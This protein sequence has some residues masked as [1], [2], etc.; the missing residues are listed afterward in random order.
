MQEREDADLRRNRTGAGAPRDD[1]AW[2][3]WAAT[4]SIV[5][6]LGCAVA[7]VWIVATREELSEAV[8][9]AGI[10]VVAAVLSGWAMWHASQA[11]IEGRPTPGWANALWLALLAA[12]FVG[13]VT[14]PVLGVAGFLGTVVGIFTV[15]V[16]AQRSARRNRAVVGSLQREEEE[17][18]RTY[19]ERRAHDERQRPPAQEARLGA[20][21]R[22]RRAEERRNLVAWILAAVPLLLGGFL[23]HAP[24]PFGVAVAGFAVCAVL[25]VGRRLTGA[26]LAERDFQRADTPPRRAFVVLL[27]DPA[28]K[29]VRPLLAVWAERPVSKDGSVSQGRPGLPRRRGGRRPAVLPGQRRAARG[30]GRHRLHARG[31]SRGGSPP[32]AGSP[33]RTDAPSWAGSTCRCCCAPSARIAR[34]GWTSA[35]RTPPAR[36]TSRRRDCRASA[37]RSPGGWLSWPRP[38]PSSPS[39][40]DLL[41]SVVTGRPDRRSGDDLSATS[42][43]PRD[44]L[45]SGGH[46]TAESGG[47]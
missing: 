30:V 7:V 21:L 9:I 1:S 33:C 23:F 39:S 32:T 18:D 36:S 10:A 24:V 19:E 4:F 22:R 2:P 44:L 35:S 38:A 31:R 15:N 26:W 45:R 27:N 34:S 37:G 28:P 46:G 8:L 47:R 5:A 13:W 3:P 14:R 20:L 17:V 40:T 42:R 29:M 25:W 6:S 16:F 41:R 12:C 11:L 43:A